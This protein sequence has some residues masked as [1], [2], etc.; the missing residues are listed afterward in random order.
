MSKIE[1]N[2]VEPQCGTN[3][4]I[5]ASGDTITFPSGT[6]VVNNGT[7]TGFGRTGAVD[8]ETTP[9][10]GNFQAAEG[11]GYFMNTTSGGL[12]VI[13]PAS[14]SAGD[15]FAVAD[16]A[17]TF[18][19]H[20]L[21]IEPHA[22]AKI[23]GV[24]ADATLDVSGQSAT[25]VYIDSTQGWINVQETETSQTG[26]PP[27]IIAT[28][29]CITTCGNFKIHTFLGPGTFSVCATSSTAANNTVGYLVV[30]GGAGGGGCAG[31]GGGAGGF[32]EGRNVPVDNFTASPLVADAPT[33]A[34]TVTATS[35]PITV[36]GGGT[37]QPAPSTQ[38]TNGVA[39]TFSSITSAGGGYAGGRGGAPTNRG[40]DGGSA[41]GN[42]ADAPTSRPS[43][44]TPP[45][46]PPQ[47][48]DGG[49]RP[50]GSYNSGG[51]GGGG[52]TQAGQDDTSPE[53]S[54]AGA[55]DGGDGATTSITGSPVARAGGGGGGGYG[56]H[57]NEGGCGGTGG[58]GRGARNDLPGPGAF[59][60][61]GTVNTGGGGG[62][63]SN[64]LPN[65]VGKGAAGGS[66]IV[67][68]RYKYQ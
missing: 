48:Q 9:Q 67:I 30:A 64:D 1:V 66:G 3:L 62:G 56:P 29:G 53:P 6:T 31:G 8:W 28:G 44:N 25:F 16:Y 52:A 45:T 13:T 26:V 23:G 27:F 49:T 14:P 39:S 22:S 43:G 36:G 38:A 59:A 60:V 65:C 32:R 4:T 20:N 7:Q 21:T 57:P 47:G 61:S 35:Y 19:T 12:T 51:M 18:A 68:I 24:A 2:T 11:K 41:G 54:Q 55:P 46:S 33:N 63:G 5:G 40:A 58:G 17:R 10:A 50:C 42:A 34:V 15:I 37:G